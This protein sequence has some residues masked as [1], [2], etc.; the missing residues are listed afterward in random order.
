MTDPLKQYLD[1]YRAEHGHIDAGSCPAMNARRAAALGQLEAHG[2]PTRRT[3]EYKYTAVRDALAPDY[4]LN[5]ARLPLA[6]DPHKLYHCSLPNIGARTCYIINDTVSPV[7]E[8]GG[9]DTIRVVPFAKADEEMRGFIGKY[10][11]STVHS[12]DALAELNTLLAQEGLLVLIPKGYRAAQPLQLVC[13]AD[14]KADLMANRRLLVVAEPGAE[15]T[16]LICEHASSAA[17]YLTTQVTELVLGERARVELCTV[18]ETGS[19]CTRFHNVYADLAAG[20]ALKLNGITLTCGRSRQ[21]TEVRL[22]APE[23]SVEANGA[24]TIAAEEHAD[25]NILVRHDAADCR[26]TLLYKYVLDGD[27]IGAF[28]GKV[29]VAPGAQRSLSEQTNANLCVSPV[30]HAFSQPMLEIYADDVKCNHG[31]TV[32]KLDETAL[33]YLRQ[34][35]IPEAEARLLLQHAFVNDVLR[36]IQPESLRQRLSLLVEKRFRGELRRCDGCRMY[37]GTATN[38]LTP[39]EP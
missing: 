35:G 37:G 12:Y 38:S 7:P 34:R 20:A 8:E 19:N 16:L 23:A 4:G 18:E 26:S 21:T 39:Q 28:A 22:T 31:S 27:A 2:L 29:Y 10:Y 14:A 30:A 11:H 33:F 32:G 25:H 1:L 13:F 24:V 36:H 3:E 5:I 15:A 17:R 9:E 6:A